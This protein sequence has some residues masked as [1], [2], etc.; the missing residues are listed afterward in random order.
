[1]KTN[2]NSGIYKIENTFSKNIYIGSSCNIKTRWS[3]HLC[4][5]RLNKHNNK[6]LQNIY[7]KYGQDT[8]KFEMVIY[9]PKEYL[10]KAEQWFINNLKPKYNHHKI[11]SIHGGKKGNYSSRMSE[12]SMGIKNPFYGKT[13]SEEFKTYRIRC[14]Q[15]KVIQLSLEG[16]YIT[17]H[18]SGKIAAKAIGGK[19]AN[20][21]YYCCARQ[22]KTA[23]GFKWKWYNQ[24][25]K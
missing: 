8:L 13:H 20:G 1:M 9:C 2:R 3:N 23:Y 25:E 12:M 17:T 24:Q 16:K 11:A 19:T 10:I 18:T 15:K 5:L 14:L 22:R 7:N 4:A 6:R 21:I